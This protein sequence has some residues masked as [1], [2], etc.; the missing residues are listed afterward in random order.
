[1]SKDSTKNVVPTLADV[2]RAAG[3]SSA[4]VSRVLNQPSLVHDN[5][6]Q[7]VMQKVREL[8]YHPNF[9]AR[10]LASKRTHTIGIIIPSLDNYYYVK[11]LSAIEESLKDLRISVLVA[12]SNY[13]SA[14]ERNQV[15][16]LISRGAEGILCFRDT[17]HA[18][19]DDTVISKT[20][21]LIT[22]GSRACRGA[23]SMI[24]FNNRQAM[25]ELALYAV[26][27]G[28]KNIAYI[29]AHLNK[30]TF[31]FERLEGVQDA[32]RHSGISP[33]ELRLYETHSTFDG[34]SD[35]FE[36]LMADDPTTTLVMCSNDILAVGVATK[37]LSMK[38]SIP[39]DLSITGFYDLDIARVIEPKLTT[40]MV[41]IAQMGRR[42]AMAM[43][44]FIVNNTMPTGAVLL[45]TRLCIRGT[46]APPKQVECV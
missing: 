44:D 29:T 22:I 7:V 19:T 30:N 9:G 36:K 37:A 3:V 33:S 15:D 2:A 1:M 34:G 46:L 13:N 31:L 40:V 12:T 32:L 10:A 41:P 39:A 11:C 18:D 25:A 17:T 24:G 28:H 16:R 45:E 27:M 23:M 21:P 42:A 14:I 43:V 26:A 4:T 35:S 5:T 20:T 8:G 6:F 38:Y